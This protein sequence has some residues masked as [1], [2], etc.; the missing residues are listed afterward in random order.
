MSWDE[1][2]PACHP[3]DAAQAHDVVRSLAPPVP[4]APRWIG[5]H[6]AGRDRGE[7]W[8]DAVSHAL[9]DRYGRWACGWCWGIGEG[10]HDGGPVGG[11]CCVP[12]SIT[13][14]EQTLTL[15][16][17]SLI[18]WRE[19][20]EDL[21]ARFD[22]LLPTLDP[23]QGPAQLAV[24]WEIAVAQL[25]VTVVDRT[26]AESGWYYHC[27]QVLMWLLTAAD[28]AEQDRARMI[29]DAIGGRFHS[30]SEP[31]PPDV[32]DV[33]QRLAH[34]VTGQRM[35][36]TTPPT[37]PDDDLSAWLSVRERIDWRTVTGRV[38]G[39]AHG[40]RDAVA[41]HARHRDTD[42]GGRLSAAV[43]EVRQAAAAGGPLTFALLADW[44][45][46]VLGVDEAGF[47][48]GPAYAKR[49][50]ESY[51]WWPELPDRFDDLLAEA[52]GDDVP[53]PARAARVYLDV[54]FVHPF[55][56]G[57]ARSAMLALY[58]VLAREGV[59]LDHAAPLLSVSRVAPDKAGA[60]GFAGLVEVLINST[61]RRM[62]RGTAPVE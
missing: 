8:R 37:S 13:S 18:E 16:A 59:V 7:R 50:R 56:D 45:R 11:W 39:P 35:V 20:L 33:A 41:E 10:D 60:A 51:A 62:R 14:A 44:Q 55:A 4:A 21:A 22:R 27:S 1:V 28:V 43:E 40:D 57:N 9:V 49:K 47:R 31:A 34:L 36:V 17:D 38:S 3:F 52:T 32:S 19:W 2:D 54:A 5:S 25:V 23:Q 61:R 24:A 6:L 26:E 58:Y 29:V 42:D 46:T 15:V 53:L 12:H 48:T 30:W